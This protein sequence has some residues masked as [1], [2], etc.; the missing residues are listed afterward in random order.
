MV[1]Y[2]QLTNALLSCKLASIAAQQHRRLVHGNHS[3]VVLQAPRDCC[4]LLLALTC[5]ADIISRQHVSHHIN[6][7][8]D[9]K[10]ESGRPFT[11]FCK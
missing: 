1:F 7:N 3:A 8:S 11:I 10:M 9:C 5:Q 6:L 4:G 2:H